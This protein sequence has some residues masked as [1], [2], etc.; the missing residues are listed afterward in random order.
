MNVRGRRI[1]SLFTALAMVLCLFTACNGKKT[2]STTVD[3]EYLASQRN[4]KVEDATDLFAPYDYIKFATIAAPESEDFQIEFYELS[5]ESFAASFYSINKN[6]L[7]M[8]RSADAIE[9]SKSGDNFDLFKLESDTRYM[10]IER[11]ENTVVFVDK[12]NSTYR[13]EIESFLKELKY[14]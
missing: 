11:V 12:T 5:D 14:L 13:D 10:M 9:T 1:F 2:V 4:Y 6:N 7:Q 8:S 3:F